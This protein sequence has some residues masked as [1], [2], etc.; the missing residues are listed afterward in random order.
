MQGHDGGGEFWKAV[1]AQARRSGAATRDAG[2]PA[3][4]PKHGPIAPGALEALSS[5]PESSIMVPA[6]DV[7]MGLPWSLVA[8]RHANVELP[9]SGTRTRVGP[10]RGGFARW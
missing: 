8:R 1:G 6:V 10:G 7:S 2:T 4:L 5:C 3:P 9:S